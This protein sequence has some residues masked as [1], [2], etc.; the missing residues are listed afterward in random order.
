[1]IPRRNC[2]WPLILILSICLAF[3]ASGCLW[4]FVTDA[5][6][7]AAIPGA[8]VRYTDSE[9][10]TDSTTTNTIGLYAFDIA[11]GPVPALGTATFGVVAPGYEPLIQAHLI[12]YDDNPHATLDNPSSFWEIQDFGLVRETVEVIEV[13]LV[14]IDIQDAMV[15]TGPGV[16]TRYRYDY[17]VYS[18]DDPDTPACRHESAWATLSSEDPP[19]ESVSHLCTVTGGDFLATLTVMVEQRAGTAVNL[20]TSTA[21]WGWAVPHPYWTYGI[22]QST[23]EAGPD[24]KDLRF[25]AHIGYRFVTAIPLGP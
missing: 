7:G 13:E 8:T 2:L 1:M 12:A 5:D 6:T 16:T 18:R 11:T 9:G 3:L 10:N 20:D 21:S 25:E 15:A 4:G 23:D 17:S 19:P 22:M 14:M 24:D